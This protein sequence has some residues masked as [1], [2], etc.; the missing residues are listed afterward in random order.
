[1]ARFV[2]M[3]QNYWG[4]GISVAGSLAAARDAGGEGNFITYQLPEGARGVRV[5]GV[6]GVV[7]WT[8]ASSPWKEVARND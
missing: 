8:G 5:N 2:T 6:T 7:S 4:T 1:M 3:M